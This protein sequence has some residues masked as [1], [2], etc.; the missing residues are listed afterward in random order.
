MVSHSI[1]YPTT[2]DA[3][4]FPSTPMTSS[5]PNDDYNL[6]TT[7]ERMDGALPATSYGR[8]HHPHANMLLL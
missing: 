1:N 2:D 6:S 5:Q 7:A 4:R 3:S 8:R